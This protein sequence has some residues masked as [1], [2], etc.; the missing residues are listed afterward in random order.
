MERLRD[1]LGIHIVKLDEEE[2]VFDLVG[3]DASLAN[4]LRRILLAEVRGGEG[5][6][7]ARL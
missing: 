7:Q 6:R 5:R 4:A 2:M 1:D 3:V